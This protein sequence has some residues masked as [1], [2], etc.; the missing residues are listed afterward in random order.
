[1][2]ELIGGVLRTKVNWEQIFAQKL[3]QDFFFS[4]YFWLLLTFNRVVKKWVLHTLE[5][6]VFKIE[7]IKKCQSK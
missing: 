5:G 1:M 3:V 2:I 6:I 4:F 7:A